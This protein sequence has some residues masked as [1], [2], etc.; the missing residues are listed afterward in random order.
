[1]EEVEVQLSTVWPDYVFEEDYELM[2]L[3]QLE[4]H[5][6]DNG[7]LPGMPSAEEM[8]DA[9]MAIGEMQLQ[10][11]EKVEELTLYVIGLKKELDLVKWQKDEM[12]RLLVER[13]VHAEGD[14]Q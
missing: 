13:G 12:T 4:K 2:P 3:D 1:M 10:L 6:N 9:T 7:H 5:I 11:L 8:E 14:A